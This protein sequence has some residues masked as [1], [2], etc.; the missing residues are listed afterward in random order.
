MRAAVVR[1]ARVDRMLAG[2]IIVA[3]ALAVAAAAFTSRPAGVSGQTG[4]ALTPPSEELQ[5]ATA[6]I[7]VSV[8]PFMGG[9]KASASS[10][11]TVRVLDV[12]TAESRP[13]RRRLPPTSAT[14]ADRFIEATQGG[15]PLVG[16]QISVGFTGR[17]TLSG[18]LTRAQTAQVCM[19]AGMKPPGVGLEDLIVS[20]GQR[21]GA[22]LDG[23]RVCVDFVFTEAGT[24]VVGARTQPVIPE[25]T[26]FYTATGG[27][28]TWGP[29]LTRGFFAAV[30]PA[31]TIVEVSPD[32]GLYVQACANGVLGY[33]AELAGTGFEIQPVLATHWVRGEDG[34]FAGADPPAADTGDGRYFPQTGHN[35]RGAFLTAFLALG[36]VEVA[37]YPITEARAA[38]PGFTDQYFQHLKLRMDDATGEVTIRPVG[39]EFVA[40]LAATHAA[41]AKV[42]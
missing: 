18:S 31:G 4:P 25:F 8:G 26:A 9:A 14:A 12:S 19:P 34:R 20:P 22:R 15:Q 2:W 3:V 38:G 28:T 32:A 21:I 29:C 37:G 17:G 11:A 1:L 16:V 39:R 36:G 40:M 35:V 13:S 27:A 41:E 10:P 7:K 5:E 6:E 33:S 23:Q 24:F 30:G 42:S